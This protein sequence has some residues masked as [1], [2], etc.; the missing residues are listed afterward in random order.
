MWVRKGQFVSAAEVPESL[1]SLRLISL[2]MDYI[3]LAIYPLILAYVCA[4]QRYQG[5][6]SNLGWIRVIQK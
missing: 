6:L 1:L 3:Y 5:S 4:H 2:V